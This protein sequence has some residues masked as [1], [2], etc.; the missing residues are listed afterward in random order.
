MSSKL[1]IL[2]AP[3]DWGLGHTTRCLPVIKQLLLDNHSVTLAAPENILNFVQATFPQIKTLSLQGYGITYSKSRRLFAAR[4]VSQIPKI[5]KAIRNEHQWLQQIQKIEK[6]D[7][8][9]SDNR[10]G[11]YHPQ[12]PCAIMTHQLQIQ[13][14]MGKAADKLLRRLH[15][16]YLEKFDTCWIVDEAGEKNLAG[17][18]SHPENIPSN[19]RY[20]GILSQMDLFQKNKTETDIHPESATKEILILLSGPEPMRTLLE[21]KLLR[22]CS[23]I[24]EKYQINFIAGKQT[25][26]EN[27]KTIHQGI[28]FYNRL[29]AEQIYPLLQRADL[30][31]CRSGYSTLMDLA[32]L[33]KKALLV[34][35]P[36]QTEQEYLAQFLNKKFKTKI[37]Q[38]ENIQL[39]KDIPAALLGE[40]ILINAKHST[41]FSQII[42]NLTSKKLNNEGH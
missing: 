20:T 28:N 23:S 19:A 42:K 7:F 1:K 30:V 39:D 22:Q 36:G 16:R 40:P 17:K 34:P 26:K 8:I 2:I 11:L 18:L 41:H 12:V 29:S 3:L 35:T 6:F 32:L 14:G 4:I 25:T 33:G 27:S 15:Y 37:A 10:Y 21:K 13:S 38:Q 31:I 9:I 24:A 5:V